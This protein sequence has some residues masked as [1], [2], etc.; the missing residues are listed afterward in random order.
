MPKA[1]YL[2]HGT[3]RMSDSAGCYAATVAR[4]DGL[5][6]RD[7][8]IAEFEPSH[9]S[10]N[11]AQTSNRS[12]VISEFEATNSVSN[13]LG[14]ISGH[15]AL[16]SRRLTLWI[17]RVG[18]DERFDESHHGSRV[19]DTRLNDSQWLRIKSQDTVRHTADAH[20]DT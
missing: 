12:L 18:V 9:R 19:A 5:G 14:A 10:V 3:S 1:H 7:K 16:K 11:S 4:P 17:A 8:L 13:G 2:Q 20:D 15:C 6:P